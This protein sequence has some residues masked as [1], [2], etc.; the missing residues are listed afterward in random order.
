MN[1]KKNVLNAFE[2]LSTYHLAGVCIRRS[3]GLRVFGGSVYLYSTIGVKVRQRIAAVFRKPRIS[4][5]TDRTL[6]RIETIARLSAT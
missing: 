1:L 5:S 3:V 2:T 4:F 6:S